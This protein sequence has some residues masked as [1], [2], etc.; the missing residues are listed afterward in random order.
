MPANPYQQFMQQNVSTMTPTQLLI[1]LY[2]KAEQELKKSIYYIESKDIQNA[3]TSLL[4][5]QEIVSMLDG[6]LKMKYEVSEGLTKIYS[7]LQDRLIMA[8]IHK[9]AEVVRE[10]IPFFSELKESFSLAVKKAH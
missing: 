1:A 3:N 7:F 10:I 5:V 4:K 2:D 8:N 6:S 9:D